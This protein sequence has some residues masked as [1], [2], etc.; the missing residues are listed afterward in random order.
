MERA[1]EHSISKWLSCM[2]KI[3]GLNI[4]TPLEHYDKIA[5]N[6]FAR[7]NDVMAANAVCERERAT[8]KFD[9]T[10]WTGK[11]TVIIENL[12]TETRWRRSK[13]WKCL[14]VI[15]IDDFFYR[16]LQWFRLCSVRKFDSPFRKLNGILECLQ[17]QKQ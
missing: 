12:W 5:M 2:G 11:M 3:W 7:V 16:K 8:K 15:S 9:E 6:L 14:F 4:R 10:R 13:T 17:G 1:S